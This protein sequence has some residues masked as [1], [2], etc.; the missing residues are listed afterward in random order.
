MVKKLQKASR[1]LMKEKRGKHGEVTDFFLQ[2]SIT[3]NTQRGGRKPM[4]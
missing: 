1:I 3:T 2:P 4:Q